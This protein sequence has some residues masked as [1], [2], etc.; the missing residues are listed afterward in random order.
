MLSWDFQ[1]LDVDQPP[2]L[3][4]EPEA[5][6]L[7]CLPMLR[8]AQRLSCWQTNQEKQSLKRPLIG[9]S[10]W[11]QVCFKTLVSLDAAVLITRRA[12]GAALTLPPAAPEGSETAWRG[13]WR[14]LL[15]SLSW[16]TKNKQWDRCLAQGR[17]IK[18]SLLSS[19]KTKRFGRS[20]SAGGQKL[21]PRFD[22]IP[23]WPL[24]PERQ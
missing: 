8:S 15:Q 18:K 4:V 14:I 22:W 23:H 10:V 11:E 19:G 24:T 17:M 20:F 5:L 2:Q 16:N 21:P 1:K 12:M 6:S 3:C 13:S 9:A 7:L